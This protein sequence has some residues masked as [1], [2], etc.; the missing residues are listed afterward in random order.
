MQELGRK[1][2]YLVWLCLAV[3]GA[4]YLL[5]ISL[6]LGFAGGVPYVIV[7]LIAL[8]IPCHNCVVYF[9]VLGSALTILGYFTSPAGG[10]LWKVLS[11]RTMALLAIWAVA[12]IGLGMRRARDA[13]KEAH[14]QLEVR[15][16]DRT[17]TL[18]EEVG[19]RRRTEESL[20]ESEE[21]YRVLFEEANESIILIEAATGDIVDFNDRACGVLGYTREE[22]KGLKIADF[23]ADQSSDVI[24]EHVR[25]I[26][27]EGSDNFE[28]RHRT[29]DGDIRDVLVSARLISIGDRPYILSLLSDITRIKRTEESLRE[30]EEKYRTLLKH[31]PQKVFLKDRDSVYI[32]CNERY[33][34]DLN[35]SPDE[36]RGRTDFDFYPVELADKYRADDKKIMDSGK[37]EELEESYIYKGE[38][39]VVHTIKTPVFDGD[40][41]V[42]ALHGIFWD[43]TEKKRAED[44]LKEAHAELEGKVRD[45]TAELLE[46]V[47]ERKQAEGALKAS[48]A[49]KEVLLKEIHHRV[50]NNLQVITS[51]LN[52]Q[53]QYIDDPAM[54]DIFRESQ[55]RIRSMAMIHERLYQSSDLSKIDFANYVKNLAASIFSSYKIGRAP[56]R[57]AVDMPE[58]VID[59]DTCVSLGLII[60]EL[61]SNSLKYAFPEGRGGEISIGL[62]PCMDGKCVLTIKDDGI[63]LPEGF[64]TR[65]AGSMGHQLIDSMV[66][67]IGGEMD[68]SSGEGASF[69]ITFPCLGDRKG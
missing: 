7:V 48:L 16:E 45:R 11:N 34:D 62:S 55:S 50:K 43:V 58:T 54:K 27:E 56:V 67:Q 41:R 25:K 53:S 60:N 2:K 46:E 32:S 68:V 6:P 10:E 12:L 9:A 13:L 17:R 26:R 21:K 64:E 33:A 31:L 39:L 8:S 5:D 1:G 36:I 19:V 37:T 44:A 63:G 40:G 47:E 28:T 4:I 14:D 65:E 24:L 61:C 52:L 49:E 69:K 30:S 22:F 20:R 29:K 42:V 38:E 59:I 51:I 18:F 15:V 57:L 3:A 23:E 35:I 66:A